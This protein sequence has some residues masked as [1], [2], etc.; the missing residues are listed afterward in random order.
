[1][2]SGGIAAMGNTIFPSETLA[3]GLA[4]DFDPASHPLIR[5]RILHPLIALT[6]GVYLFVSLGF[7]WWLKPAPEARGLVRA[8]FATY[9]VQLVIGT[10]NLAFLAPV[11]LQLIHLAVAVLAYGLLAALSIVLLGAEVP[12]RAS[13]SAA[14]AV[15]ASPSGAG[16]DGAGRTAMEN[17]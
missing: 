15:S 6:V 2:F 3:A 14:D 11:V 4:A 10:A 1:M 17:A 7:G 8:L 12:A 16:S 9:V 13:A 5:L